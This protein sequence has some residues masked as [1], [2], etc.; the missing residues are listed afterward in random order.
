MNMFSVLCKMPLH[1]I[2]STLCNEK[3]KQICVRFYHY[4]QIA[5]MAEIVSIYVN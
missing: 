5:K 4:L 2:I 1:I 3:K